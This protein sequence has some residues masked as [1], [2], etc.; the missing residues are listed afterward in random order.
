MDQTIGDDFHRKSGRWM[1]LYRLFDRVKRW[2]HE[3]VTDPE[4]GEVV[5]EC[6]EPLTNHRGHGSDKTKH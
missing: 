3:R 5:H 4:T 2:Y 1:K 6:S